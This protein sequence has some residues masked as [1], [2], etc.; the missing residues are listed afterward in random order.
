MYWPAQ[1]NTLDKNTERIS[2]NNKM[3]INSH[4]G[5][6]FVVMVLLLSV[7]YLPRT[8]REPA[9]IKILECKQTIFLPMLLITTYLFK[10]ERIII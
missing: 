2:Q 10:V 8:E 9:S 5:G 4:L 7:L 3:L 6:K 1:S